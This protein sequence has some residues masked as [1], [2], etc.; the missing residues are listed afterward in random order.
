MSLVW[1]GDRVLLKWE[2]LVKFQ[3][4]KIEQISSLVG[5]HKQVAEY[6]LYS[7]RIIEDDD[8]IINSMTAK[9]PFNKHSD[10]TL[11]SMLEAY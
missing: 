6:H 3:A 2:N 9:L 11:Q 7:L 10:A 4:I 1:Q 8:Y 5:N